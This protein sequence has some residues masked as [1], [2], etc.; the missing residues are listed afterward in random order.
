MRLFD[1]SGRLRVYKVCSCYKGVMTE[2]ENHWF[3]PY[4]CKN[5]FEWKAWSRRPARWSWCI[6]SEFLCTHS[7]TH[8]CGLILKGMNNG[9]WLGFQREGERMLNEMKTDVWLW[10][11]ATKA[12]P[13][14]LDESTHTNPLPI[15]GQ[16]CHAVRNVPVSGGMSPGGGVVGSGRLPA[17]RK[18]CLCSVSNDSLSRRDIFGD[19]LQLGKK[20]GAIRLLTEDITSQQI[21][22]IKKSDVHLPWVSPQD[23][24]LGDWVRW[25]GCGWDDPHKCSASDD[26]ASS[27]SVFW[28]GGYS[29][30]VSL[31]QTPAQSHNHHVTI[32]KVFLPLNAGDRFKS[33]NFNIQFGYCIMTQKK[34]SDT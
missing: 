15:C 8:T 12:W 28:G 24:V 4:V 22:F 19:I 7:L 9:C 29:E 26:C 16:T 11:G 32:Q 6:T 13:L 20:K 27:S 1:Y 31:S 14:V 33:K 18:R 30:A 23:Q 17:A 10:Q 25:P 34:Y 3:N 5:P 21:P 2:P